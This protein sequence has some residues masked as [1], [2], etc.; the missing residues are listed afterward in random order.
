MMEWKQL[1]GAYFLSAGYEIWVLSNNP[2][3]FI[4]WH[5]SSPVGARLKEL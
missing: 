1:T 5:L 2:E 4:I 3:Y